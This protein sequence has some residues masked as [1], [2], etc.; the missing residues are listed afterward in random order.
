ME[1][2]N[3]IVSIKRIKK[4]EY[5]EEISREIWNTIMIEI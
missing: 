4:I 1:D 3:K 5:N 2:N